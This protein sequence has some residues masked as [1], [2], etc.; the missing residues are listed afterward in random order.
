MAAFT[1]IIPYLDV[2]LVSGWSRLLL[3]PVWPSED[4]RTS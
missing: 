2:R 1:L 4:G 3:R